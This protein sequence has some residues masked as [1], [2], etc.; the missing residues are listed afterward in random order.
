M[1][2]V[3]LCVIEERLCLPVFLLIQT[4]DSGV[5]PVVIDGEALIIVDARC[6]ALELTF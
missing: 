2:G 3:F 4:I 6:S 5:S 1:E